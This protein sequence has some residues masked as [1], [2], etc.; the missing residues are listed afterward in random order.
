M[1][2]TAVDKSV[3]F[4]YAG[5]LADDESMDLAEQ[6]VHGIGQFAG[7]YNAEDMATVTSSAGA[8][9]MDAFL[10][11]GGTVLVINYQK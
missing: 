11:S 6:L 10:R 8:G 4:L 2:S 5:D 7:L 1:S 9:G 3:K